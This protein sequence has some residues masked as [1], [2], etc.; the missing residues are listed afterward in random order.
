[1]LHTEISPWLVCVRIWWAYWSLKGKIG[2]NLKKVVYYHGL[3]CFTNKLHIPSIRFC[4]STA[5]NVHYYN[6][7]LLLELTRSCISMEKQT[8]SK[9]VLLPLRV[10]FAFKKKIEGWTPGMTKHTLLEESAP[11]EQFTWSPSERTTKHFS[12]HSY[13]QYVHFRHPAGYWCL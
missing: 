4:R 13:V 9:I 12:I 5:W 1:M 10:V 11:V 3:Q 2:V 8:G 7:Q 6:V